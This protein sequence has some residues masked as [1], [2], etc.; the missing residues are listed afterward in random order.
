[1]PRQRKRHVQIELPK[2]DKNGQRRGGKRPN[3]GRPAKGPRPSE[4][5]ET[6]A[7]FKRGEPIHVIMRATPEVGS[8]RKRSIMRAVHE[9][10][11]IVTRHEARFRIVHLSLQRTHIHLIVEAENRVALATGMQAFGISAARNINRVIGERIGKKQSGR[12]F[13]DR[14]HA[15]ILKT[16]RQVRNT[17]AYVLNNW[18]H[19]GED[20]RDFARNWVI[21]PFASGCC[22]AGW[23]ERDDKGYTYRAPPGYVGFVVWQPSLWL[24]REGWRRWGLISAYEVPGSGVE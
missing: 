2:L 11:I 3:A 4:R 8:L 6:R 24:L 14:Y 15:R 22:F 21:D 1:V 12:V 23:K 20:T 5:H 17:I 9:A 13:A 10:T 7:V 18:R 19:H 16:P